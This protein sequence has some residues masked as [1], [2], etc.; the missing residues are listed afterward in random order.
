[1]ADRKRIELKAAYS[2]REIAELS[3]LSRHQI[4]RILGAAGLKT[5]RPPLTDRGGRGV[6]VAGRRKRWIWASD[7]KEHLPR[8]WE[9]LVDL[10]AAWAARRRP[11]P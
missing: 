3:G 2:I 4:A 9:S 11:E 5:S 10:D 7:L 8:L 6:S 1:M